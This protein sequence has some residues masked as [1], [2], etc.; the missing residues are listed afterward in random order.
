MSTGNLFL[1]IELEAQIRDFTQY[2]H[3]STKK[4]SN[5][6]LAQRF[7]NCVL[8]DQHT[9]TPSQGLESILSNSIHDLAAFLLP[10]LITETSILK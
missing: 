8:W 2:T 7:P 3:F 5:H 10:S 4:K 1:R 6:A 9:D